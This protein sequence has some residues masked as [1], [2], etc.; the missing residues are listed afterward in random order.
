MLHYAHSVC[1]G[2]IVAGPWVRL[3]CKRHLDDVVHG[4]A[5]GLVW[6]LDKALRAIRF[7]ETVLRLN[8][9]DFEG[10]PFLLQPWQKFCVGSVF[11]WYGVDGYRRFRSAFEEIGKGNG[12]SPMAAG[13]G[14]YMLVGDGEERAECYSAAVDKAQAGILFRD[15]VAMVDQSPSLRD[16][17]KKSGATGREWNLAYLKTHSFFRPIASETKGKGKSGPRPHFAALDELHE[18]PTAA[19]ANFMRAGTK[20]RKQALILKI[21]NSGVDRKSVCWHEH[22]YAIRVL[23]GLAFDDTLFAYVC[24]LDEKDDWKDEAVW[25]KANPNLGVSIDMKY[26][27]ELVHDAEGMPSKQS[28]T[29]RLNFCEWVDAEA[30]WIDG[31]KWRACVGPVDRS[32]LKGRRC[33]GGLDLSGKTAF[34]AYTEVYP[35]ASEGGRA[36]AVTY[37]WTPQEGLKQ[38]E[39]HDLA[40]YAQWVRE[41]HLLTT[42]GGS[43][44]YAYAA[45]QIKKAVDDGRLKELAFDRWRMEDF[46]RELDDLSVNYEVLDFGVETETFPDLI[47][48][49]HGQG[50][51]DMAP[52]VDELENRVINCGMTVEDNPVM[53]MCSANAVLTSDP[54]GSRKFDK[55]K[56][57]G[58]IDGIISLA[59]AARCEALAPK[60]Q[61]SFWE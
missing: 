40:P 44:D 20:G 32:S 13:T 45:L 43:V 29:K 15:A 37:F 50:F 17:V 47:L 54:A 1:D 6:R 21:T 53:T 2:A 26:L 25:L 30:P 19:M 34:T 35:P 51:K 9:G 46:K 10:K 12:K 24:A 33:F 11:G 61:K 49:P 8:G 41:G 59:M 4:P 7:F 39:E 42:P 57:A 5:R 52:A 23:K 27:R 48:R 3:A 55:R 38:R 56:A 22:E 58:R 36:I 28:L 16:R 60:E 18:H 31:D 14:L